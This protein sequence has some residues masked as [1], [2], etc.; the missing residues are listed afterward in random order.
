MEN[1]LSNNTTKKTMDYANT[2]TKSII[3]QTENDLDIESN[4]ERECNNL[5]KSARR[6]IQPKCCLFCSP[7]YKRYEESCSL[8]KMAGDKYKSAHCWHK[9][10][11]CYENCSLIKKRLQQNPLNYYE[12]AYYCYDKMD[13]SNDLKNIFDMMNSLLEKEGKFF[14]VG[15][16]YENMGIKMEKKENYDIAIE[17]YLL[18]MKYYEKDFKHE[19]IKTKLL[20]KLCELMVLHNYSKAENYVPNMLENIGINYLKNIMI[21]YMAKEYFG[22]AVLTRIYF[23]DDIQEAKLYINKYK[24]K[25]KSFEDS[26]IYILCKDF[27]SLIEHGENDKLNN[28]V[29]KYKEICGI[30]EYL[31][32]IL[33]NIIDRENQKKK[34]KDKENNENNNDIITDSANNSPEDNTINNNNNINSNDE[35]NINEIN[36][37]EEN[38]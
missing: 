17:Y 11:I 23:N 38:K 6:K 22:K 10:A 28:A 18:A 14:Q 21:K 13:F 26:N 25:D 19:N 33:D 31:T 9:A 16:N 30:D 4:L 24:N 15:K 3:N 12:Q 34:L 5:I 2:F 1:N 8:Y 37:N 35:G 32:F 27:I 29:Q 36:K 7:K 20:I